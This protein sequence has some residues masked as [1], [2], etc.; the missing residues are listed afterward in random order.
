MDYCGKFSTS[1][2]VGPDGAAT[3]IAR[4]RRHYGSLCGVEGDLIET[5]VARGIVGIERE[6]VVTRVAILGDIDPVVLD[7]GNELVN[8]A[9][10]EVENMLEVT[11]AGVGEDKAR[12]DTVTGISLQVG[13]VS[14]RNVRGVL[15][16]VGVSLDVVRIH[17]VEKLV[18]RTEVQTFADRR[19]ERLPKVHS[20]L[21]GQSTVGVIQNRERCGR[22]TDTLNP[23]EGHETLKLCLTD[24]GQWSDTLEVREIPGECQDVIDTRSVRVARHHIN[25]LVEA[26]LAEVIKRTAVESSVRAVRRAETRG[27]Q[28]RRS[29]KNIGQRESAKTGEDVD[30][31]R[32][33][34]VA[35]RLRGPS[36]SPGDRLVDMHVRE[37][38]H[39]RRDNGARLRTGTS[40]ANVH[41]RI[42]SAGELTHQSNAIRVTPK[43]SGIRLDPVQKE[44][45]VREPIVFHL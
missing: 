29:R 25:I 16:N 38:G 39:G 27:S 7:R 15:P 32:L 40:V 11:L 10:R 1:A 18:S 2:I 43:R 41:H 6:P 36:K 3:I 37:I 4:R 19:T 20:W 26:S 9:G 45:L 28:A 13:V 8:L 5:V 34:A 24:V 35:R 30:R 44:H 17:D 14:A 12:G 42:D 22:Q 21:C 23:V 33:V 31:R